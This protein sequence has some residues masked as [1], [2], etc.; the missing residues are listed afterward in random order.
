MT[1]Q[2]STH[3]WTKLNPSER[4]PPPPVKIFFNFMFFAR[5][6]PVFPA[7][8]KILHPPLSIFKFY[9]PFQFVILFYANTV[10]TSEMN[11]TS[12]A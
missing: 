8:R 6:L 9:L 1:E 4:L 5:I 10:T 12:S 2:D 7:P 3:M 11:I